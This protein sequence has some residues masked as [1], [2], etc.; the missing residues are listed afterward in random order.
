M[1]GT[2]CPA[3]QASVT[4]RG[5]GDTTE[6]LTAATDEHG[7]WEAPIPYAIPA[8]PVTVVASCGDI[9]YGPITFERRGPAAPVPTAPA[10]TPAP[11]P[12]PGATPAAPVGGAPSYTG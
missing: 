11:V 3:D 9:A 12:G 2:D 5:A 4:F 10:T 7:D 1:V 8:G 6:T